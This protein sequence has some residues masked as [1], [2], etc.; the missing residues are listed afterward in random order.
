MYIL[1]YKDGHD[2]AAC[3]LKD[4]HIVAA[5]EEERFLRIKHAPSYFPKESIAY[6]LREAGIK[7]E[8][9]DHVVFARYTAVPTLF[10]VLGYYA[11]RP[12]KN[13]VELRYAFSHIKIQLWGVWGELRGGK[14]RELRKEFPNLPIPTSPFDHHTCHAASAFLFSPFEESV[15]ITW[16]GKGEATSTMI[17]K[18][19]GTEITPLKRWGIFDSLGLLYSAATEYLGFTPNDGEYKVMGL[20]PYGKAG[21]DIGD[22]ITPDETEGYKV[23]SNFVLYPFA[24]KSFT[25]RFGPPRSREAKMNE[26]Q[27]DLAFALQDALEQAGISTAKLGKNLFDSKY[28][29]F[30]GGV[31]LNVKL[32][33]VLRESGLFEDIFV[34]PAAGDNGLVLGAAA[35]LYGKLT[36]KRPEPLTHL[37]LGPAYSDVEIESVLKNRGIAYKK[38]AEISKDA[39]KL[40]AD[41]LVVAWFEGRMEFGPRSLGSRSVLANPATA[42]MRDHVNAKIK[43]R[44]EFR[45]F[46]PSVL[47][48]QA[49]N[50]LVRAAP[51][52]YMILSFEATDAAKRLMPAVVHVDGTVRPQTVSKLAHPR[53]RGL[54]EQHY[55]LTGTPGVLNTSLNVRGEPIVESPDHLVDFFLKTNVDAIVGGNCI[56]LRSAQDPKVFVTLSRETLKT[57]Y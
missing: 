14:Y 28:A 55:I 42:L 5:A 30:A 43:F 1:A 2:P 41:G 15:V 13:A 36:G 4:G 34:Q 49:P 40:I 12:P 8:D 19:S 18:G 11:S 24:Q 17:A 38:S 45:P 9:V 31:A 21:T 20:A 46:C 56:A 51:S 6:C 27:Q 29:C 53:Y 57:E 37:Y 26:E 35:L 48:E 16:D 25:K 52:P 7:E 44:E 10:S 54:L 33:R 32:N 47:E 23:N 22:M 50:L 39:A 3:I